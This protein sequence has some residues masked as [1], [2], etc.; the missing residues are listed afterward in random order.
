MVLSVHLVCLCF[1]LF[2][3]EAVC[4][5]FTIP[6]VD[7]LFFSYEETELRRDF[8]RWKKVLFSLF[9]LRHAHISNF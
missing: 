3:I 4:N 8:T 5:L 2:N 6:E 7:G 1:N 9:R